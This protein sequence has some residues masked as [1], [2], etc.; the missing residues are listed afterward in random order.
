MICSLNFFGDGAA[1][2]RDQRRS[3]ERM[4]LPINSGFSLRAMVSTSGSSGIFGVRCDVASV[5]YHV[6]ALGT[7]HSLYSLNISPTLRPSCARRITSPSME[8]IERTVM[9]P[10]SGFIF[11]G[12]MGTVSVVIM[13]L[14][15]SFASR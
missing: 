8:E 6:A 3:A 11:F 12:G 2:V 14:M 1:S 10:L 5:I 9:R 4:V 13:C 7:R 15:G